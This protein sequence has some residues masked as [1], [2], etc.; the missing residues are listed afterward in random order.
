MCCLISIVDFDVRFRCLISTLTIDIDFGVDF[1]IDIDVQ[2]HQLRG[3]VERR[4]GRQATLTQG[5][6]RARAHDPTA[7]TRVQS[8]LRPSPPL[9]GGGAAAPPPREVTRRPP[10]PSF[11]P[12]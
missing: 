6:E 1:D 2:V 4:A 12:L 3:H 9:D 11:E 8:T 10:P 7:Y 5:G